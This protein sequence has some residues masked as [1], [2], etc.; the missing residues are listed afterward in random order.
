MTDAI[1][2]FSGYSHIDYL[3][4]K[5]DLREVTDIIFLHVQHAFPHMSFP[6]C[7]WPPPCTTL[8][9]Q[10]VMTISNITTLT[11]F[12]WL[13]KAATKEQKGA[14]LD[15]ALGLFIWGW[16]GQELYCFRQGQD[17]ALLSRVWD[18]SGLSPMMMQGDNH[19]GMFLQ[20][21][22]WLLK[23]IKCKGRKK[24]KKAA[25]YSWLTLLKE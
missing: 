22:Y 21:K 1:L 6:S 13:W 23:E 11:S 19:M 18:T 14:F 15:A 5:T 12:N 24:K 3:L 8:G 20:L 10:Q 2:S 7:M 25:V 4:H 17:G 16:E 9:V